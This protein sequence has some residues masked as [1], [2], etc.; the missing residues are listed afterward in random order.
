MKMADWVKK[1][2]DFLTLNDRDILTDSGKVTHS[3]AEELAG[4][5]YELFDANRKKFEANNPVSDFDKA[6]KR[7]EQTMPR[8]PKPQ[9]KGKKAK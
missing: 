8:T 5:Q 1:L 2:H 6:V 3:L 4:K 7:I 9:R